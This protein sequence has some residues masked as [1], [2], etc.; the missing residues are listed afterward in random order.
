MCLVPPPGEDNNEMASGC[1]ISQNKPLEWRCY[2][3]AI[4]KSHTEFFWSFRQ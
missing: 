4:Y 2:V 1:E 3:E